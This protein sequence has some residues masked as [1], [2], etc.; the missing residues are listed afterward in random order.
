MKGWLWLAGLTPCFVLLALVTCGEPPSD[1]R[2]GIDAPSE[3]QFP[4]VSDLLDYRCGSLDC[5]GNPQRNLVI[6]G[7]NG[8]RLEPPDASLDAGTL[9][10]PGCRN[11]G[12]ANTTPA[13]YNATYRSLVGLEPTVM[14]TVV[15]GPPPGAHPELLTFIRKARGWEAHKGGH[16]WDAGDTS[17]D[18]ATSWLAGMTNTADCK[19]ALAT[20]P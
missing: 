15:M 2:I 14:S 13:E 20:S 12:G 3:S 6:W 11:S 5:H 16:I 1:A 4:P 7:C 10:V 9:L 18:C 8:L 19:T 17:D